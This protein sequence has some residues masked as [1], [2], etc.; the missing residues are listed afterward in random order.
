MGEVLEDGTGT[1]NKAQVFKSKRLSTQSLSLPAR[2][3][4]SDDER[5]FS[6]N[7]GS[8]TLTSANESG[9]LYLKNNEADNLRIDG[10]GVAFEASTGGTGLVR[11]NVY[12]NPTTGTLISD[13][14]D[15]PIVSN[16]NFSSSIELAADV[17]IGGVASTVTDG[18]VHTYTTQSTQTGALLT[19]AI[20]LGKG[21]SL[22]ITFTPPSGNTSI[23]CNAV[24]LG[25]LAEITE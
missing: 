5:A 22:A 16:A 10:I 4:A 24:F 1:G 15:A 3:G 25:H 17:F 12:R 9:V 14:T 19:T 18:T 13:A 8:I 7:S 11:I 21:A 23:R 2:L 20:V 6:M